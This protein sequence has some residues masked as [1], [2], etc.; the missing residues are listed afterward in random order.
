[1]QGATKCAVKGAHVVAGDKLCRGDKMCRNNSP[2]AYTEIVI[3]GGGGGGA[4]VE[5]EVT[6]GSAK[7][8][9]C[10]RPRGVWGHALPGK[11]LKYLS[12]TVHYKNILKVIWEQKLDYCC[13]K[14][15]R[16]SNLGGARA[17]WAPHEYAPAP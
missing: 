10:Y 5:G 13:S 6:V 16:S 14:I 1:M 11:F 2:G 17:C 4:G 7:G 9:S 15:L 3:E 12:Q 8:P